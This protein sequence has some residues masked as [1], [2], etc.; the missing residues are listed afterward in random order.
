[1]HV[2]ES[3]GLGVAPFRVSQFIEMGGNC[4]YCGT[5]IKLSCVVSDADGKTFVVGSD[6]VRKT[7]DK[8]IVKQLSD[9]EKRRRAE[10]RK[11]AWVEECKFFASAAETFR[12]IRAALEAQP[13]PRIDGKVLSNYV[14]FLIANRSGYKIL[15]AILKKYT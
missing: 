13:H 10:A 3:A 4:A 9:A 14:D 6:C 7:G 5:K 15:Q 1:M 2:F 12:P 8:G 11:R